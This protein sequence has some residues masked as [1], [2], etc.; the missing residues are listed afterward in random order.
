MRQQIKTKNNLASELKEPVKYNGPT[1]SVT[2]VSET[3]EALAT[4]PV[5]AVFAKA[6][7]SVQGKAEA[8]PDLAL[9]LVDKRAS[10]ISPDQAPTFSDQL[11]D[12]ASLFYQ[13]LASR[14]DDLEQEL[15]DETEEKH[16]QVAA[17]EAL[18][19]RHSTLLEILPA[20]VVILDGHGYVCEANP[21]AVELL[22]KPLKDQLWLDVIQRSFSPRH[23]DGHEVSLQDGRRVRIE[24]RSLTSETGQLVLISDLTETRQLQEQVS[25][26]ERLG[27]LGKMVASLAH[28]IRTPLSTAM[29]YAGH[30]RQKSLDDEMRLDCADKLL[31]RLTHLEHQIRDML[32]FA[33]GET[34]LAEQLSMP[35]FFESLKCAALPILQKH[36]VDTDWQNSSEGQILCNKETLVGACLNLI[37]NSVEAYEQANMGNDLRLRLS[38]SVQD[39]GNTTDNN[40]EQR[41]AC[42]QIL[43]NGPGIPEPLCAQVTDAF[44]TT[45]PQGTGLGLAVVKAVVKAH[46]GQFSIKSNVQGTV[47]SIVLPLFQIKSPSVAPKN[48]QE[49]P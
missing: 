11:S 1:P 3:A 10:M 24:T 44:F 45:K 40:A 17:R 15:E 36:N 5:Q 31:A 38:I 49:K 6:S 12:P 28:Q 26:T 16:A 46:H 32:I 34:R 4:K 19:R 27:S 9:E 48:V 35:E 13:N 30:L 29:L 22:G 2:R 37:N 42:I 25:R 39:R 21:A 47:A 41:Y 18:A 23:D 14:L 33:K 7:H 8:T 20:G 43:D